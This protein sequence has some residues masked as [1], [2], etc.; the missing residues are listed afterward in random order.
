M[1]HEQ[2]AAFLRLQE[3]D[4]DMDALLNSTSPA[5]K[6]FRQQV[7]TYR[8]GRAPRAPPA[9]STQSTDPQPNPNSNQDKS[10]DA[11]KKPSKDEATAQRIKK[12]FEWLMDVAK[13]K[14]ISAEEFA[15]EI[16]TP[17]AESKA[18]CEDHAL[19]RLLR[20]YDGVYKGAA[21]PSSWK[22]ALGTT[23][24]E[25]GRKTLHD[26]IKLH[27]T[28][29]GLTGME[30]AVKQESL[31]SQHSLSA[32]SSVFANS[33]LH[34]LGCIIFAKERACLSQ[35]ECAELNRI[36][37][38]EQQP[39]LAEASHEERDELLKGKYKQQYNTW[40]RSRSRFIGGRNRLCDLYN[41]FGPAVLLDPFWTQ[42]SLDTNQRTP[43]FPAL[44][45][46]VLESVPPDPDN[47]EVLISDA[48]YESSWRALIGATAGIDSKLTAL[49]DEVMIM[50]PDSARTA[51]AQESDD[52]D[53]NE[54][55]GE[56][57][58]A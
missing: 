46:L 43:D 57:N 14:P 19:G 1:S 35:T 24:E 34:Q 17:F 9:L 40:K 33:I 29:T 18:N 6:E 39:E 50:H 20:G 53:E 32:N 13:Q 25:R 49:V 54:D 22:M 4:I 37:Y 44:L 45:A 23:F 5:T 8:S 48:R 41:K 21:A 16:K 52:V 42:H 58:A 30:A 55:G 38:A 26:V 56:V 47:P 3:A 10:K 27:K 2:I 12:R 28:A 36:C 15:A 11:P 51:E 7:E 31:L